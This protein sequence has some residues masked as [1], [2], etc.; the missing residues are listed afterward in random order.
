METYECRVVEPS[1]PKDL[2]RLFCFTGKAIRLDTQ[3]HGVQIWMVAYQV[4]FPV[5]EQLPWLSMA[6][7]ET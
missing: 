5:R 4:L 6:D 1:D 3:L 2:W 7:T